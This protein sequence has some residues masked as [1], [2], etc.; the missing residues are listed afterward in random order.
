[1]F[2]TLPKET[3]RERERNDEKSVIAD[4]AGADG[5]AA[6]RALVAFPS[7]FI[8]AGFYFIAGEQ[9]NNWHST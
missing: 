3:E 9:A 7:D 1:M 2:L 8:V 5:T 6:V 4:A